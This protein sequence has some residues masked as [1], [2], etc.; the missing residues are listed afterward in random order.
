M[1]GRLWYVLPLFATPE[2]HGG[3][4]IIKSLMWPVDVS[5]LW[6]LGTLPLFMAVM[7]GAEMS[8]D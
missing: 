7:S 4:S 1:V 5:V 3:H 6:P 8:G 2:S